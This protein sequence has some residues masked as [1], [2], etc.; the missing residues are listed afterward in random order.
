MYYVVYIIIFSCIHC[1][2]AAAVV[3]VV[4]CLFFAMGLFGLF[5]ACVRAF[6]FISGYRR[7]GLELFFGLGGVFFLRAW[8]G[9]VGGD[10]VR[11][12]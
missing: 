12:L 8:R 11:E 9:E 1:F 10:G 3:D 4:E 6:L 2:F 5:C 7:W